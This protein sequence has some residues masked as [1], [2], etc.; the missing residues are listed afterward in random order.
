LAG[1]HLVSEI[2]VTKNLNSFMTQQEDITK[3][4]LY[5]FIGLGGTG[6]SVCIKSPSK[7]KK[8]YNKFFLLYE[9]E[10][11]VEA[12]TKDSLRKEVKK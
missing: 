8:K 2:A 7:N 9:Q 6:T 3:I 5:S 11:I 12:S 10:T 1:L 4:S